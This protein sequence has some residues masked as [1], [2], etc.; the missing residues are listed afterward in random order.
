LQYFDPTKY[1][2]ISELHAGDEGKILFDVPVRVERERVDGTDYT[3]TWIGNQTVDIDP[4]GPISPLP[5]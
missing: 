1:V 3:T 5:F 4:R 2:R